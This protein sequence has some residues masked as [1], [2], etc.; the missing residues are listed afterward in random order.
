MCI[1]NVCTR[2]HHVIPAG[3]KYLDTPSISHN[4]EIIK[5]IDS[6][7]TDKKSEG[8]GKYKYDKKIFRCKE[9]SSELSDFNLEF[10]FADSG[11][12]CFKH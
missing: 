5:E 10:S 3:D 9:I 2:R 12:K 6:Q 11:V 4:T 7:V 1:D 8:L